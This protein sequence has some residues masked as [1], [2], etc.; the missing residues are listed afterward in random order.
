[1]LSDFEEM[2][3]ILKRQYP[4]CYTRKSKSEQIVIECESL[5]FDFDLDGNFNYIVNYKE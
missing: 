5:I 4:S 1:M 3:N 2:L